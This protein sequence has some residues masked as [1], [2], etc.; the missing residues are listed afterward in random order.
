MYDNMKTDNIFAFTSTV[1]FV[2][3]FYV[4]G[5]VIHLRYVCCLSQ[6]LFEILMFP[7]IEF[8][9]YVSVITM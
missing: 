9:P 6:L 7:L 5:S 1:F 3:M 2:M 8:T 4:E